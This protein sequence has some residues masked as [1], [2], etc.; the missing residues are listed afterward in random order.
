MRFFTLATALLASIVSVTAAPPKKCKAKNQKKVEVEPRYLIQ[1]LGFENGSCSLPQFYKKGEG[2]KISPDPD[3]AHTG[4]KS[5]FFEVDAT[6]Q[7]PSIEFRDLDGLETNGS[8]TL[9][10]YYRVVKGDNI[11]SAEQ[12]QIR[13]GVVGY[14]AVQILATGAPLEFNLYEEFYMYVHNFEGNWGG[15]DFSLMFGCEWGLGSGSSV[16]ISIDDISLKKGYERRPPG[17]KLVR[18]GFYLPLARRIDIGKP[19]FGPMW[20]SPWPNG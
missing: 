6:K 1:N 7:F 2:V 8:Y 5:L 4:K 20:L 16:A 11:T 10:G 12:C 18:Q 14:Q 19:W 13:A 3:L 17:S 15:K 9:K